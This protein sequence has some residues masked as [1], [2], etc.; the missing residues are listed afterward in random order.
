MFFNN[1]LQKQLIILSTKF[2][3]KD[4]KRI[5]TQK[6]NIYFIDNTWSLDVLELKDYGLENNRGYI[7]APVILDDFGKFGWAIP[8]KKMLEQ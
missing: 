6:T 5:R 8:F 2:A 7:N 3:L 1:K 4:R